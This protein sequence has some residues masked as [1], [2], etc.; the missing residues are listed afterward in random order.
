MTR[1]LA[2]IFLEALLTA[3]C[4]AAAGPLLDVLLIEG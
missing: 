3:V 1:R 4:V 2:R